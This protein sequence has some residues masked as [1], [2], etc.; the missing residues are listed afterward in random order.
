LWALQAGRA[1][2]PGLA[3]QAGHPSGT[4]EALRALRAYRPERSGRTRRPARA[5]SAA[6]K[7]PEIIKGAVIPGVVLAMLEE[8]AVLTGDDGRVDRD[9]AGGQPVRQRHAIADPRRRARHRRA[10]LNNGPN[11]LGR[12]FGSRL[13]S[14]LGATGRFL[15]RVRP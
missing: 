3:G 8:H 9:G 12:C 15:V 1:L 14:R 5:G 7:S 4:G 2:R 11:V 10:R 13:A 6:A